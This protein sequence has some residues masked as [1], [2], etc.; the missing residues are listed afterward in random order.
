[1]LT[2]SWNNLGLAIVQSPDIPHDRKPLACAMAIGESGRGVTWVARELLNFWSLKQRDGFGTEGVLA[3]D[4]YTY[5]RMLSYT[6]AVRVFWLRI[7][8]SP[9]YDG[10]DEYLKKGDREALD[11]FGRRFCP[12]GYDGSPA[13]A[14]WSRDT[15]FSTYTDYILSF[16]REALE[17][18]QA[19][20]YRVTSPAP[21]DPEPEP[22]LSLEP[23]FKVVQV[24]ADLR[25]DGAIW[26][27]VKNFDRYRVNPIHSLVHYSAALEG[28]DVDKGTM[29]SWNVRLTQASAH[30]YLTRRNPRVF[31]C[32]P[33]QFWAWGAGRLNPL[34][35]HEEVEN[36]GCFEDNEKKVRSWYDPFARR[37]CRWFWPGIIRSAP[38]EEFVWLQH[39]KDQR[40]RWWHTYPEDQIALLIELLRAQKVFAPRIRFDGH[41]MYEPTRLDPGPAFPWAQV[42]AALA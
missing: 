22:G 3:P 35:W 1:M 32:V 36:L 25:V 12:P 27:P 41:D 13:H 38:I 11:F 31:Q 39:P 29:A 34:A 7:H 20:G 28:D 8:M 40:F 21:R 30:F 24:G 10:I 19:S 4:G 42:R 9:Y 37:F 18:L 2:D 6:Q 33:L 26:H 23:R 17:H 16:M 15:G 5:M 14:K